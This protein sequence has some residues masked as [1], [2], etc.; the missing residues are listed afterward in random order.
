MSANQPFPP[1]FPGGD[2]EFNDAPTLPIRPSTPEA[3]PTPP[4]QP[5]EAAAYAA[6][7]FPQPPLPAAPPSWP[8]AAEANNSQQAGGFPPPQHGFGP[9]QGFG[10]PPAPGAPGGM[11]APPRKRRTGLIVLIAVAL[12]VVVAGGVVGFI[13]LRNGG[14]AST[15]P[16]TL[17][18]YTTFTSPDHTFCLAYPNGWQVTNALRGTGAQFSGPAQQKFSVAN[19]GA[20]SGTPTAYDVAFCASLHS[21]ANALTTVTISGQAWTQAHCAI[22]AGAGRAVVESIIYKGSLYHLDY[23]SSAATF[24]SDLSQFFTPIEQSF[25]FL[26]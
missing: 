25:N 17:S 7:Q 20:F 18:G 12:L 22:N 6:T 13:V 11:A 10:G 3:M 15:P 1:A 16:C 24:Q 9:P 14:A 19:I 5:A 8:P 2:S 4:L 26:T 21:R 23:G